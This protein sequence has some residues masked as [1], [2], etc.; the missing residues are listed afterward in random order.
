M[1]F[2]DKHYF[3]M[4]CISSYSVFRL[5]SSNPVMRKGNRMIESKMKEWFLFIFF[6][7]INPLL[8]WREHV[9]RGHEATSDL[10]MWE[11]QGMEGRGWR[12]GVGSWASELLC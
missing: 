10:H 5:A 12:A 4:A 9:H 1:V 3:H 6:S 7:A 2:V 8:P 11:G